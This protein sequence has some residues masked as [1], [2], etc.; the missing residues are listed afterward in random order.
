MPGSVG[1]QGAIV[2]TTL[3]NFFEDYAKTYDAFDVR[4]MSNYVACPLVTVYEG[5]PTC[6]NDSAEV[7]SFFSKLLEWFRDIEHGTASISNLNVQPLGDRSAFASVLWRSTRADKASFLEWSTAYQ[8][9]KP[10]GNWKILTIILRYEAA[11][12]TSLT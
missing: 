11:Q 10:S 12:T 2:T 7:E 8:L 5:E 9:I 3:R 1:G 6:H 4:G